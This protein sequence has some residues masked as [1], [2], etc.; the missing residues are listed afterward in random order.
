[1]GCVLSVELLASAVILGGVV[2]V[3][4]DTTLGYYCSCE[5]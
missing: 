1:M 5:K 4:V 3:I 2:C